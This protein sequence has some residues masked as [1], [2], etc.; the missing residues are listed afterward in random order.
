MG[1]T[2]ATNRAPIGNAAIP[3]GNPIVVVW[4]FDSPVVSNVPSDVNGGGTTT[5]LRGLSADTA[6]PA[7]AV[8]GASV[9]RSGSTAT[10]PPPSLEI[11]V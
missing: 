4:L 5:L 6:S 3:G 8:T 1:T 11:G 10:V 7:E 9:R 2:V